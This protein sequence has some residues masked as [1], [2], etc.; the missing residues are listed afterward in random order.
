MV[1]FLSTDVVTIAGAQVKDQTFAEALK[2]PG[3]TFVAARFDGILGL[4]FPSISGMIWDF[5]N[6]IL[7][8]NEF[9]D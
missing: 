6:E 5:K 8:K 4:G 9:F 2:E 3:I 1:G 7:L